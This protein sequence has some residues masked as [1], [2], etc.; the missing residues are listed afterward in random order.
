VSANFPQA[1]TQFDNNKVC[2][3]KRIY[4]NKYLNKKIKYDDGGTLPTNTNCW[5]VILPT[6][7]N[8]STTSAYTPGN[9]S[10]A[11]HHNYEDA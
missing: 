4:F 3:T 5:L 9:I 6:Y 2:T 1:N 7:G 10:Y 8:G 11:I